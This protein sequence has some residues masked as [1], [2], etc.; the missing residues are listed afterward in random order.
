MAI[1]F[2]QLPHS[3]IT[4]KIRSCSSIAIEKFQSPKRMGDGKLQLPSTIIILWMAIEV[5]RSPKKEGMPNV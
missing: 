3:N 1:N 2:F 4:K 5:F